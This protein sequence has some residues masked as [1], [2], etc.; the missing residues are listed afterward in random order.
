MELQKFIK[1]ELKLSDDTLIENIEKLLSKREEF[2]KVIAQIDSMFLDTNDKIFQHWK[3]TIN[4]NECYNQYNKL[5]SK[6]REAGIIIDTVKVSVYMHDDSKLYCQV[7]AISEQS[8]SDEIKLKIIELLPNA[9][10]AYTFQRFENDYDR[11]F[12]CFEKVV[13][14]L[15]E[16]HN[17]I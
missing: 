7:D 4:N 14:K 16:K 3:N 12:K 11:A 5:D 13:K 8:L 2:S 10:T 1:N 15:T 9:R 17:L 6:P